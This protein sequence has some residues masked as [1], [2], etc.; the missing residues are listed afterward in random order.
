MRMKMRAEGPFE[1]DSVLYY[2]PEHQQGEE[3][4]N[5]GTADG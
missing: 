4:R 5:V 2:L 3:K 1:G